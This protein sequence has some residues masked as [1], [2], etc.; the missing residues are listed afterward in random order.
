MLLVCAYAGVRMLTP[1]IV[2]CGLRIACRGLML[3]VCAEHCVIECVSA[4][5]QRVLTMGAVYCI[6]GVWM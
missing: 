6:C 1:Y 3:A 2:P 5:V 4:I